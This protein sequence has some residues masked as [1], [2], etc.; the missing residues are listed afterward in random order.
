MIIIIY[1]VTLAIIYIIYNNIN[2]KKEL[3][4]LVHK[5][6]KLLFIYK[7]KINN[8]K[9]IDTFISNSNSNSNKKNIINKNESCKC[10]NEPLFVVNNIPN[11]PINDIVTQ[12][13]TKSYDIVYD[14]DN[15]VLNNKLY[16]PLGR[17]ERPQ[18]DILMNYI[19]TQPGMFN[20]FT[21]GTPDTFRPIGYLT[22]K[23]G[24]QTIDN[25]LIL[26]GRSKFPNSDI[27]EFYATSSSKISDIKIPLNQNNCNIKK[28]S[29]IPMN[30]SITGNMLCGNYDFTELPKTELTYPYI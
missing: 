11:H 10:K 26:Y 8:E 3:K 30:V 13:N 9:K 7:K 24:N 20:E 15:N 4:K 5:Y 18:F 27:G 19:N 12:K 21:R 23:T 1:S 25:T 28:I 16:P 2:E 29:D 22:L 14:R 17:T 6:E